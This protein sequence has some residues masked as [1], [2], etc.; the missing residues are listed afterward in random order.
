MQHK[1]LAPQDSHSPSQER[2]ENNTGSS[3]P[4]LKAVKY[5]GIGTLYPSLSISNATDDVRGLTQAIIQNGSSGYILCYG[6]MYNVDTS[7]WAPGTSLFAD[8]NGD[9]TDVSGGGPQVANVLKQ[10]ATLGV[11]AVTCLDT[12]A[13][14]VANVQD[15]DS[16]D[17]DTLG[18]LIKSDLR[19]STNPATASHEKAISTIKSG[20]SKGL[21]VEYP[22]AD[23]DTNGILT[24]TDWNT[25]NGRVQQTDPRLSV[26]NVLKVK[27]NPGTGEFATISAAIAA[28]VSGTPIDTNRYLVHVAPGVYSEP[29]L[30]VPSFVYVMGYSRDSV[31][32][33]PNANNHHIFSI[34]ANSG[35]GSL[36]LRNAGSGFAAVLAED[37]GPQ[38]SAIENL[39]ID[40]CDYGVIVRTSIGATGPHSVYLKHTLINESITSAVQQITLGAGLSYFDVDQVSMFASGTNS[41]VGIEV[42]GSA[43]KAKITSMLLV[44]T[45]GGPFG[46]GI[47]TVNGA[48]S[49]VHATELEGWNHAVHIGGSNSEAR[50]TATTFS[51]CNINV[52]ASD[53]TSTGFFDGYTEYSKIDI[54]PTSNF[55]ITNKDAN[56]LTVAKKG[57]DFTSVKDAVD[58]IADNSSSNRYIVQ[59]GPGIFTEDTITMKEYVSI[60]GSAFA[61]TIIEADGPNKH[62]IIASRFAEISR[63]TLTGVSGAGF[64]LVKLVG[65]TGWTGHQVF[66]LRGCVLGASDIL[67]HSE[68]DTG[69]A[70]IFVEGCNFGDGYA[71]NTGFL[72]STVGAGTGRMVIRNCTTVGGTIAPNPTDMFLVHGAGCEMLISA[73]LVSVNTT[74]PEGIG[75]RVYDG[76]RLRM[77]GCSFRGFDKGLV[78]DNAG[79]A[80]I[81]EVANCAYALNTKDIEVNHLTAAGTIT[82]AAA[83]AKT[84]I[85]STSP[86]F[87]IA[88]ID[89]EDPGLLFNGKLNYIENDPNYAV[90]IAPL[91]TSGSTMGAIHGGALTDGGGLDLDVAEGFG[92][93][94]A[95]DYPDHAL[96]RYDWANSTLTLSASQASYIFINT[97]GILSASASL[98][99]SINVILLGRVVT[100]S[101]SIIYIE[102]APLDAHH[103]GNKIDRLLREALGP[104]YANGSIT[105][106]TGVRQLAV[107]SGK[108]FFS[109][110]V[111][112]PTGGSPI[113]WDAYYRGVTPGTYTKIAA[114]STVSNTQYDDGSG[115]LAS[116]PA[117]EY[118]KHAVWILGGPSEKYLFVYGQATYPSLAAVETASL[119]VP[120]GFVSDSF[121]RLAAII[122]QEGTANIITVLDERPRLGF[123][124]SGTASTS[125]HS[126][127]SDLTNDD[128][129]QYLRTDGGRILTG[130]LNMGDND[131]TNVDLV[132]GVDVS[133]HDARHLPNGADPLATAAPVTAVGGNTANGVGSANSFSRSDHQHA[134][135]TGTPSTIT[136]DQANAAGSSNNLA[137]A[138]HIHNV[139][140]DVAVGLDANSTNTEGVGAA[141]ARND[142]THD[143]AT[144]VVSAQAPDQV[145]AE[146]VS[147]NLARADHVH[148]IPTAAPVT[149]NAD[150]SNNQG[151]AA[152]FSRADHKHNIATAAPV[153]QAPDQANAA[154][155]ST[156]L[157]RADHV[158][159]IPADAPVTTLSPATTNAE[160]S[161]SAFA[162]NDHTHAVA[163]GLVGDIQSIEPDDA[164]AAGTAD[165]FA[166]ADHQHAIA[167]D[168]PVT[169]NPDQANAEGVST[170]FARA[171]HVHNVPAATP[172][173]LNPDQ[174][175]A[176]GVST[177]FA[178][179]DHVHSVPAD[180]AVSIATDSVNAEGVS[181]SF[182]RADHTHA[183]SIPN[184]QATATADA[185]T[186]SATYVLLTGM[187]L[188]PAAGTYLVM[189]STSV[190][191][192]TD[193]ADVFVNIYVGGAIVA[194]TE[195]QATP[196]NTA[197]GAATQSIGLA[198]QTIATVNG[199]QAIEARWRTTAATATAHERTLT[200]VRLNN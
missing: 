14:L 198:T 129:L 38:G 175:N 53:P 76:A 149:A 120:P 144:G 106:E 31:I 156:S 44:R 99:S 189:F 97:S 66:F 171:D 15:T 67:V 186:T 91:V 121:A 166:R 122:V 37:S 158:H 90:N 136:P 30:N 118:V 74:S 77:I 7:A 115:T 2:V 155:V 140:A 178:R 93:L 60:L 173:T 102:S 107:S 69:P 163:T 83:F 145:S 65:L 32:V 8:A 21:H 143:L 72:A 51:D 162:R 126:A 177:S 125:S 36:T 75:A 164:A 4:A 196:Q 88:V 26:M 80:P 108:Y 147:A 184:N 128:H 135:A 130:N 169:L 56:I 133:D 182:A 81:L 20:P 16:I 176:E 28:A 193:N 9:L 199:S 57:G 179:A 104:V 58:S 191:H 29:Q 114:Q 195:R 46:H 13:A 141:F 117:G 187:T 146:G 96:K 62:L 48:F 103:Y 92:Y 11:L 119:P 52:H 152:T 19:L 98:P 22:W 18:N 82:G 87:A 43:A 132:D 188:T 78:V 3:I 84:T 131:I 35:V 59:V 148:N 138:D 61:Q 101:S 190:D 68:G 39:S 95:V 40:N 153:T 41:P 70:S 55:F 79:A 142:H 174:A 24:S 54:N 185:T 47:N 116:I 5:T 167:A 17:M 183:I 49:S 94:E 33:E 127:L 27:Q 172:V 137:R 139:P 170:S 1:N 154:G 180:V 123:T 42:T 192:N 181:T 150:G 124:A 25:F 194:H 197:F 160:G 168:A 34:G 111:Y 105:S 12:P 159:N 134:V 112:Q 64:A 45:A 63:C 100:D 73:C 86:N 50:I 110:K 109:E 161:G 6:F 113:T 151:V 89:P 157:A 71:F 85:A 200:I 165:R 23:T 10:H